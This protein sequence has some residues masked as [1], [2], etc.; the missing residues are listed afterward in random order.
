MPDS[1]SGAFAM[2]R[3]HAAEEFLDAHAVDGDEDD[4]S[5]GGRLGRGKREAAREHDCAGGEAPCGA[6]LDQF[7]PLMT[8][9]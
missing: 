6:S 2:H 1:A 8:R 5:V 7:K 3:V 9:S 4:V